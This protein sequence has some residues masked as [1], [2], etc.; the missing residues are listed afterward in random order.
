MILRRL[1]ALRFVFRF[2]LDFCRNIRLV[3]ME[4]G[5]YVAANEEHKGMGFVG[6]PKGTDN[7]L[8]RATQSK[9]ARVGIHT[10]NGR[11]LVLQR[12]DH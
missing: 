6:G 9:A 7:V 8:G 3:V 11:Q 12:G 2:G 5:P 10:I 1:V 4:K